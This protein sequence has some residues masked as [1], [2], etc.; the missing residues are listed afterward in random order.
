MRIPAKLNWSLRLTG[1]REDGYHLLQSLFLP[2]NGLTDRVSVTAQLAEQTS[3]RLNQRGPF[4]DECPD[5][6]SLNLA[7]RAALAYLEAADRSA[8]VIIDLDKQIPVAAGLGGG[9]ADAAAVLLQLENQLQSGLNLADLALKLGADVPFFLEPKPAVVSGV[10][11]IIEPVDCP[12]NGHFLLIQPP[13]AI[14]A[15]EAYGLFDGTFSASFS[16]ENWVTEA[17]QNDLMPGVCR[18]YPLIQLILADL[19]QSEVAAFGL[20]GSGPVCFAFSTSSTLLHQL[21]LDLTEK[22][23]FCRF[24]QFPLNL[25]EIA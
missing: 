23:R 10:G 8:E 16:S 7:G 14:S 21:Q 17:G 9:S 19:A 25:K 22:W 6:P 15:S 5:D 11:E 3:V 1:R 24:W 4:V 13:L 12:L 18:K 2:L 20:T